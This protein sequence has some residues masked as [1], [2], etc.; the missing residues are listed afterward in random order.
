[1]T[2][3][4]LHIISQIRQ[5][6]TNRNVIFP[7]GYDSVFRDPATSLLYYRQYGDSNEYDRFPPIDNQGNFFYLRYLENERATFE[8]INRESSCKERFRQTIILRGVFIYTANNQFEVGD[9]TLNG[10]IGTQ[11]SP[12]GNVDEIR[13]NPLSINY[14]YLNWSG[15][16]T[17]D[18]IR[19]Y[20]PAIQSFAIDIS[21]TFAREFDACRNPPELI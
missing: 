5:D 20:M 1:M 8:E 16:D 7:K 13:V 18:E 4:T 12:F 9:Y 11:L 15:E 17:A 21:I 2:S 14:D 6:I 10:I 19:T 3:E